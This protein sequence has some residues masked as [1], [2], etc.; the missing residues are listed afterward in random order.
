MLIKPPRWTHEGTEPD[1]RFSFANERT[2]LAWLRTALALLAGAIA[3]RQLAPP[4]SV[5]GAR[6]ALAVGVGVLGTVLPAYAYRRWARAQRAMRNLQ[7]LPTATGVRLIC[8]FACLVGAMVCL[9][10]VSGRAA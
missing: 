5:A 6:T 2:F 8:A 7:P 1:Y 3:L 4:F 10:I 9:L